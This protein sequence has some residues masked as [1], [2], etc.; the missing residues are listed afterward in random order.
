MGVFGR[1]GRVA[2]VRMLSIVELERASGGVVVETLARHINDRNTSAKAQRR[3][4]R[5]ISALRI[6]DAS[7]RVCPAF[8]GCDHEMSRFSNRI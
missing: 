4:T 7:S 8:V 5:A 2:F 1:L 3:T 6:L